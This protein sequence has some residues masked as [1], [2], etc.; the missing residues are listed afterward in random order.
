MRG[1]GALDSTVVG[2]VVKKLGLRRQ[3]QRRTYYCA[4]TRTEDDDL[5]RVRLIVGLGC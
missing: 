3:W 1:M 5:G 4:V 2:L